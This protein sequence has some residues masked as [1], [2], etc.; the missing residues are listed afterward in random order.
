M[1]DDL[2][3]R[4][5]RLQRVL[6][7]GIAAR[8]FHRQLAKS[9]CCSHV[10]AGKRVQ[11]MLTVLVKAWNDAGWKPDEADIEGAR[12]LTQRKNW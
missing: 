3:K 9:L 12:E 1:L 6:I 7:W 10:H 5:S 8:Q 11:Q 2:V 4:Q